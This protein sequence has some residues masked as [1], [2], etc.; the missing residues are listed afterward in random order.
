MEKPFK[1]IIKY[2]DLYL[3]DTLA[4]LGLLLNPIFKFWKPFLNSV[5][6]IF[7]WILFVGYIIHIVKLTG[8]YC[9]LEIERFS[10]KNNSNSIDLRLLREK[11]FVDCIKISQSP[12]LSSNRTYCSSLNEGSLTSLGSHYVMY[13][14]PHW[15]KYSFFI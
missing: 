3:L 13:S 2:D 4:T 7:L 14:H 11:H 12:L 10:I 15:W 8:T 1:L 9:I 5:K 6:Q